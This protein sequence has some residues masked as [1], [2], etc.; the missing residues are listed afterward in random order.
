MHWV[1]RDWLRRQVAEP[2]DGPT[3][4]VT[5][6]APS[7]GSVATPYAADWLTPAFVSELPSEFFEGSTLWAHGHTHSPFDYQRGRCR[8]VSNPR[9]YRMPDGSYENHMF[10]PRCVVEV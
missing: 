1:D 8:V 3:V 9:G 4:V 2:F 10:N 5:H 6:H 7:L